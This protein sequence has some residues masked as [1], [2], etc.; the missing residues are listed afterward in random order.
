MIDLDSIFLRKK[1]IGFKIKTNITKMR[2]CECDNL[3]CRNSTS[4]DDLR[5]Q[6]DENHEKKQEYLAKISDIIEW[7]S[8]NR[9]ASCIEKMQNLTHFW[10]CERNV[11]TF[12]H[13]SHALAN[14]I[15]R[16]EDKELTYRANQYL[17]KDPE[18]YRQLKRRKNIFE[19]LSGGIPGQK[20]GPDIPL[21]GHLEV[22]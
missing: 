1:H 19:N 17:L 22:S 3:C 2:I 9:D 6:D 8:E 4:I 13:C 18:L 20:F 11:A 15:S 14:C 21:G 5:K 10:N 7:F 16:L 12:Q